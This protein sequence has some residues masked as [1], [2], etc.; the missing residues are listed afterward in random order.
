LFISSSSIGSANFSLISLKR[1]T[2][3][4][5]LAEAF[6]DDLAHAAAG[7]E[8]GFLRQVADADA[9][10]RAGLAL[11]VLVDAGH[12]PQQ[13]GLARAVQAEHADLG[14]GEEAERDVLE[15]ETLGRN[16]LAHPV[17]CVNV[18]R[19]WICLRDCR[20]GNAARLSGK[21]RSLESYNPDHDRQS[22][23][24]PR[25]QG[26]QYRRLWFW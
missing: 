13:R 12:D 9:G 8:V 2:N 25:S 17:H 15:D 22:Q 21:R 4:D 24:R 1:L 20:A 16:D 14:A 6:L 23:C 7:V 5:H 26:R 11:D 18:L 10:L 19:H 3:C